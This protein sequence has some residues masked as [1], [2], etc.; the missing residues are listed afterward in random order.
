MTQQVPGPQTEEEWL[1]HV[2]NIHGNP[3]E[4]LCRHNLQHSPN[5]T[6]KHSR[7]PVEFPPSS[8][9]M[10]QTKN[11]E[12]D[13]WGN[14][15]S[16]GIKIE[17][18]VEC[19]KNNPEYIDWVFFPSE[20]PTLPSARTL[21]YERLDSASLPWANT[22]QTLDLAT[23]I[24]VTDDGRE[25]KGNYQ[26]KWQQS[27]NGNQRQ[28]PRDFTKTSNTAI[29]DAAHQIALATQ[30]LLLRERNSMKAPPE[31]K[32]APSSWSQVFLPLIVTT[33]KLWTCHFPVEKVDS[34]TGEVPL[35]EVQYRKQPY[36]FFT[37]ALPPILQYHPD[38]VRFVPRSDADW[39][40]LA[41]L[42]I[43]VVQS[44]EFPG[45]LMH[46]SKMTKIAGKLNLPPPLS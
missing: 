4:R 34:I 24:V 14:H 21:V 11:S 43:L 36:L 23:N 22:R 40:Q 10:G 13:L 7:Y 31:D 28:P 27:Q 20:N 44:A 29:T 46:L 39:E 26:A 30:A 18:L 35:N 15:Q 17:L 19:K 32:Y 25:T 37:Y 2:L 1:T 42:S 12:L 45:L 16:P 8:M 5:W 38:D 41:R 9:S 3:F 6:V 33:A